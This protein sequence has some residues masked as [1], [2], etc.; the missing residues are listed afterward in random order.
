[1]SCSTCCEIE[2]PEA[3]CAAAKPWCRVER[4]PRRRLIDKL[5]RVV[6]PLYAARDGWI[7]IMKGVIS[8]NASLFHSH[9]MMR[10]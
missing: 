10:R 6:L 5:E 4:R 3:T 1:M 2:R 9:R 7:R 8:R